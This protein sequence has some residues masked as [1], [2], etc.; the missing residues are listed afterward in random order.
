MNVLVTAASAT[1]STTEIA[2]RIAQGL[3]GRGIEATVEPPEAVAHVTSY[4]AVV[5]GSAVQGGH[6]LEPAVELVDRVAPELVERPVWL[7]SSGPVG[8]PGRALTRMMSAEPAEV[9]KLL[10]VTQARGHRLF[11]GRL[12]RGHQSAGRRLALRLFK[13]LEGDWRDWHAVE[14]WTDEIANTLAHAEWYRRLDGES[15]PDA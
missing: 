9:P 5:I 15:K 8:E 12:V 11:G 4:Q 1:G 10:S 14:Q 3:R 2:E 6:W 7:F 13:S